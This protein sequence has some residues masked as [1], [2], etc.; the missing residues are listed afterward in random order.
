MRAPS[1]RRCAAASTRR[2]VAVRGWLRF[3]EW[4]RWFVVVAVQLVLRDAEL[5]SRVVAARW[6]CA[7][8]SPRRLAVASLAGLGC[9]CGVAEQMAV[10]LQG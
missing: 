10:P 3:V 2:W 1:R 7:A 8:D 4:L 9:R 5:Q 6:R